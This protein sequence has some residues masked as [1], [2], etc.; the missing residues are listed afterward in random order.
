MRKPTAWRSSWAASLSWR[1]AQVVA[2]DTA[3]SAAA[4]LNVA[5]AGAEAPAAHSAAALASRCLSAVLPGRLQAAQHA[6]P[7]IRLCKR[8]GWA[9]MQPA[10]Q[11]LLQACFS[12][13][14]KRGEAVAL[15]LSLCKHA[16]K[17][18]AAPG[19][20]PAAAEQACVA[21]LCQL[22]ATT[23]CALFEQPQPQPQQAFAGPARQPAALQPATTAQLLSAL[24][25]LGGGPQLALAQRLLPHALADVDGSTVQ[26]LLLLQRRFGWAVVRPAAQRVV[27]DCQA[28]SRRLPHSM[29]LLRKL[30][31]AT[32]GG[33]AG[34][35]SGSGAATDQ[36]AAPAVAAAPGKEN[37]SRGQ[38]VQQ[39]QAAAAPTKQA[40]QT[41][42]QQ[43][44]QAWQEEALAEVAGLLAAAL[45]V[46][47]QEGDTP[48]QAAQLAVQPQH[49]WRAQQAQ[50]ARSADFVADAFRAVCALLP[51]VGT[52][53]VRP[54]VIGGLPLTGLADRLALLATRLGQLPGRY[55]AD[56]C[57]AAAC[58]QLHEKLGPAGAAG[59]HWRG[60][61]Y[62]WLAACAGERL[63]LRC[64]CPLPWQLVAQA[65]A[66]ARLCCLQA[67]PRC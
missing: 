17:A 35:A 7:T 59:G 63:T 10:L 1:L 38:Q 52:A 28:D 60:G 29:A 32:A 13:P 49:T 46:A 27:A 57:L 61:A 51:V 9:A 5:G 48:Q 53:P 6:A 56:A 44:W 4:A 41:E 24:A 65:G 11:A 15:L 8:L 21:G 40:Q 64:S 42:G 43:Q 45:D 62:P 36:Q 18:V 23:A 34:G 20:A 19:A 2:A 67:A 3:G 31:E 14:H 26:A 55:P 30:A 47:L 58:K 22:A 16:A 37:S 12:L 33:S 25:V 54:A 39:G 50:Q 66:A